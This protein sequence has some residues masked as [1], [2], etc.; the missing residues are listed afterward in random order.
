MALN[1]NKIY[2]LSIYQTFSFC[3][4]IISASLQKNKVEKEYFEKI[5]KVGY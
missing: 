2:E 1:L 3:S 4:K 5:M